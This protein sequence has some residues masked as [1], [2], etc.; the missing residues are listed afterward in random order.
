MMC[1]LAAGPGRFF[2]ALANPDAYYIS[3]TTVCPIM[4]AEFDTCTLFYRGF[5]TARFFA[6]P[7]AVG[8]PL[9]APIFDV[10][11]SGSHCPQSTFAGDRPPRSSRCDQRRR[12]RISL[13]SGPARYSGSKPNRKCSGLHTITRAI[14]VPGGW[15]VTITQTRRRSGARLFAAF[16]ARGLPIFLSAAPTNSHRPVNARQYAPCRAASV[17]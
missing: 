5:N 10:A 17:F 4:G 12:C 16:R 11:S 15:Q 3:A 2:V 7:G 1:V 14:F 13:E 6:Q 9:S 8:I